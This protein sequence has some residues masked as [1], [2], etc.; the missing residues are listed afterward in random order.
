[1]STIM[2][3]N[4]EEVNQDSYDAFVSR[5]KYSGTIPNMQFFIDHNIKFVTAP[6][7]VVDGKEMSVRTAMD[8]EIIDVKLFL[9][10]YQ[11]DYVYSIENTRH[12]DPKTFD[13]V[14][15]YK[16]RGTYS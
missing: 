9:T 10:T 11:Y 7:F 15:M 12:V 8:N 5:C 2:N 3:T 13:I 6:I 4:V 14:I 1:M 16:V